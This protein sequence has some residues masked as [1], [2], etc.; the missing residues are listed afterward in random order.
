MS[1]ERTPATHTPRPSPLFRGMQ[2][3]MGELFD[4]FRD[5]RHF[6]PGEFFEELGA[7][8][9]PAIDV[10]ENDEV[11]EVTAEVP[12]V[13]EK[14][15]EVTITRETLTLKG[16]KSSTREESEQD[17]HIV[18][19]RFG[20]FRRQIPLGFT[21]EEDAVKTHFA[22][23]VLKLTITKPKDATEPVRKIAISKG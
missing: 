1:K 4:R 13:S 18:E 2:R 22:D 21:P 23:G 11:F 19:R 7:P 3:E 9:F 14:D 15:I 6:A 8:M 12:G 20:S 17:Y 5:F 16:E 10:S